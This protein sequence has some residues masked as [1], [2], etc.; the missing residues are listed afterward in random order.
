MKMHPNHL[1]DICKACA[2]NLMA[3][4]KDKVKQ[5]IEED[6]G[7]AQAFIEKYRISKEDLDLIM[8]GISIVS[9]R[10][11]L[12]ILI[13]SGHVIEVKSIKGQRQNGPSIGV[14]PCGPE[15]FKPI[16]PNGTNGRFNHA[17]RTAG[18]MAPPAPRAG[19]PKTEVPSGW[20]EFDDENDFQDEEEETY[21]DHPGVIEFDNDPAPEPV[22]A[23]HFE[24]MTR[25]QLV[26]IIEDKLW[27][28][29]IDTD[30]A[31]KKELI[32]FL[33]AKDAQHR[34]VAEKKRR[35]AESCSAEALE[36]LQNRLAEAVKRNPHLKES[37]ERLLN[38]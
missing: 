3:D 10:T 13:L 25:K 15:N 23:P 28:S 6:G 35:H 17:P 2:G 4:L 20:N 31:S 9:V 5:L 16:F 14:P 32:E 30:E 22:M 36:A 26:G 1:T 11:F 18:P 33:E 38:N 34:E 8:N 21:G 29:E 19:R 37:V 12:K 24:T 27:S 7:N